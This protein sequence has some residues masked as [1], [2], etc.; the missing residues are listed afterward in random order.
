MLRKN[1]LNKTIAVT[2]A[3]GLI[4]SSTPV[5]ADNPM[6]YP[7]QPNMAGQQNMAGRQNNRFGQLQFN[8]NA[9]GMNQQ[10][11]KPASNSQMNNTPN[12]NMQ[13]DRTSSV[14]QGL[15]FNCLEFI[16][17]K[18]DIETTD[19]T[20]EEIAEAIIDQL[21]ELTDEK[22]DNLAKAF[23][24]NTGSMEENAII[25]AIE[26]KIDDLLLDE[27]L[28]DAID[29]MDI[30]ASGMSPDKAAAAVID[31]LD[32]LSE[33][34]LESV[35]EALGI[36]VDDMD[37]DEIIEAVETLLDVYAATSGTVELDKIAALLNI[38]TDDLT[39]SEM[40]AEIIDELAGASLEKV[41][42]IADILGIS[43]SGL[44]YSGIID[45]IEE[46]LEEID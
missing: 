24:I 14:Q 26:E 16:A 30:Y 36:D 45:K 29:I 23:F 35:A 1:L 17:G 20:N 8:W 28:A 12:I 32:E 10:N 15:F 18:L 41:M 42:H 22:L 46:T 27:N 19:L 33:D 9:F 25:E 44:T 37:E 4:L 3:A 31:G 5:F 34:E 6:G 13:Q 7:A 11:T 40:V 2:V 43:V 38:D 21:D 39:D